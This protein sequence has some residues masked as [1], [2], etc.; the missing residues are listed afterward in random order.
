MSAAKTP[1]LSLWK[2]R[3]I[4]SCC[5]NC[6]TD[7]INQIDWNCNKVE[8]FSFRF[9]IWNWIWI[10]NKCT[11]HSDEKSIYRRICIILFFTWNDTRARNAHEINLSEWKYVNVIYDWNELAIYV[12]QWMW[13][14]FNFE[15]FPSSVDVHIILLSYAC[16]IWPSVP[17]QNQLH[18]GEKKI[19]RKQVQMR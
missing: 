3:A 5:Q 1:M 6:Y 8:R 4:N 11:G 13:S 14:I 15:S 18:R 17:I 10:R 12:H 2:L 16:F 7:T 9:V 19:I